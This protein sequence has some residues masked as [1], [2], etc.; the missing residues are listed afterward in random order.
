MNRT[1]QLFELCRWIQP[2]LMKL[3]DFLNLTYMVVSNPNEATD[4]GNNGKEQ[5]HKMVF[6]VVF[7]IEWLKQVIGMRKELFPRHWTHFLHTDRSASTGGHSTS[8]CNAPF[9]PALHGQKYRC[10]PNGSNG[11]PSTSST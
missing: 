6:Q 8:V 7:I 10:W 4:P 5:F 9:H 11:G 3:F 2:L 1:L